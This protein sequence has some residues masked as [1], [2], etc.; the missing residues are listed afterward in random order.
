MPSLYSN[1]AAVVVAL[2]R[3]GSAVPVRRVAY[4]G[5]GDTVGGGARRRPEVD[6]IPSEERGNPFQDSPSWI[7]PLATLHI[8]MIITR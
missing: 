5:A 4:G 3:T 1:N 8:W 6:G 7:M 2:A